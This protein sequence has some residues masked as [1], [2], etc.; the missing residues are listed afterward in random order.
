MKTREFVITAFDRPFNPDGLTIYKAG[1][2]ERRLNADDYGFRNANILVFDKNGSLYEGGNN[3][4]S[5][6]HSVQ[7]NVILP[8]G[9]FAAAFA[10]T[11][12]IYEY[13]LLATEGAVIHNSTISLIYPMYAKCDESE[14]VLTVVADISE[15]E[16]GNT[17]KYLFV[18]N[19]CTYINGNPIKFKGLCK[20]AGLDVSVDYCTFG[21]AYFYEY[22]DE[23]HPRG[24]ALRKMLD[25]KKYDYIVLQ[26]GTPC[27][28][29]KRMEALEKLLELVKQNGAKPLLYMRYGYETDK[30]KRLA[31]NADMYGTFK[32]MGDIYD[33][34]VCPVALAFSECTLKYPEINLYADDEAH[35]SKAGSYLAACCYLYTYCKIS[36]LGNTYT[37]GLDA[38][39]A[40]KLQRIALSACGG[41][42]E[43]H[44]KETVEKAVEKKKA[45]KRKNTDTVSLKWGVAGAVLGT[46]TAVAA[47]ILVNK[48]VNTFKKNRKNKNKG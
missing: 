42:D 45:E 4:S 31:A 13:H 46:V 21:S 44:I 16:T 1:A 38:D 7:K 24:K 34:P 41:L 20:A 39:T 17:V 30:E 29:D 25:I 18:G 2:E 8:A 47:M 12:P 23:N 40:E 48:K 28:L 3:L 6:E 35:H 37:A 33:I 14:G 5:G 11:H 32:T 19:S 27:P 26:D 22:A 10:N 36:P 43:K 9:G 15:N